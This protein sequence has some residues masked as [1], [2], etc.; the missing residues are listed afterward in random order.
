MRKLAIAFISLLLFTA[1]FWTYSVKLTQAN[2]YRYIDR[3]GPPPADAI[4]LVISVSSP[5]KKSM[6]LVN[7]VTIAFTVTTQ[8]TSIYAISDIH[9]TASWLQ[10]KVTIPIQG[11]H[12]S[13][14]YNETF[15]DMA[16]GNYSISF[17][18]IG[19]GSYI[20]TTR[21][22][23]YDGTVHH[24]EMTTVST[25]TFTVAAPLE[26]SI[27][28]PKNELY[29]SSEVPLT[30]AIDKP[31]VKISYVLDYQDN[32]AINGN[33]TIT[34]LTN[35]VHNLTVYAS[36]AAGIVCSSET[37][38]FNVGVPEPDPTVL[39]L[40]VSIA[41]AVTVI[42]GLILHYMKRRSEGEQR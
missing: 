37:V 13:A 33:A 11:L 41:L 38:T 7:D 29:G 17:T 16:N 25:I 28:S 1:T 3:W 4:P 39:I 40:A 30:L 2:P 8:D 22:D 15:H 10:D 14:S 19:S 21:I 6:Y 27:L 9:F 18:A 24:Y 42:A 36:D 5:E 35:G 34:D 32:I 12:K 23:Y 31:F 20:D 26:V